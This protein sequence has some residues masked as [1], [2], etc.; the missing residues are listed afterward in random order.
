[1][2]DVKETVPPP[3]LETIGEFDVHVVQFEAQ[4]L[5]WDLTINLL[6]DSYERITTE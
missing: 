2:N 3:V 6:T 4:E 5:T 1:M